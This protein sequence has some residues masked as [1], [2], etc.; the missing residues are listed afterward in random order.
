MPPV[1]GTSMWCQC[2]SS[3]YCATSTQISLAWRCPGFMW[4]WSSQPFAGILRITGVTPL[5]TSTGELGLWGARVNSQDPGCDHSMCPLSTWTG[6]SRRLGMGYPH[7]QQNIWRRWWRSW[8][9]SSLIASLTSCTNLSP[10]WTPIP[11]CPMACRWVPKKQTRGRNDLVMPFVVVVV[12]IIC[13]LPLPLFHS[14]LSCLGYQFH[15]T[16]SNSK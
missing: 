3:P 15:E 1:D 12:V 7:L 11:S 13:N 6:V 9:L 8:H 2:W 16:N 5:T 14:V 4:A 10:S